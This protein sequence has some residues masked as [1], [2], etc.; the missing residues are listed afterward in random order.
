MPCPTGESWGREERDGG[1]GEREGRT[2]EKGKK[3][4]EQAC[5]LRMLRLSLSIRREWNK[6]A[7]MANHA[8][9]VRLKLRQEF[10]AELATVRCPHLIFL[11]QER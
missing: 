11:D 4:E 9:G 7:T 2:R 10:G 1:R 5:R 6:A 8:E 3:G